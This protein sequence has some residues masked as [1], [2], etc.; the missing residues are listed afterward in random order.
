MPE[1]LVPVDVVGHSSGVVAISATSF[2]DACAV[3]ATGGVKC[4]GANAEGEL[5]DGSATTSLVPVD[6]VGL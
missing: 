3:T 4:W 2:G 6:V 5:G 1:S